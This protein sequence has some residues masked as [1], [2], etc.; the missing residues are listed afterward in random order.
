MKNGGL[1]ANEAFRVTPKST[2]LAL[3]RQP[4]FNSTRVPYKSDGMHKNKPPA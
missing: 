2:R 1:T 4:L 3:R